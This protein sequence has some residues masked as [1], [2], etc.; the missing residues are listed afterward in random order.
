MFTYRGQ[1]RLYRTVNSVPIIATYVDNRY[2]YH[3]VQED[4]VN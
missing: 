2:M 1:V 4:Y 3:H